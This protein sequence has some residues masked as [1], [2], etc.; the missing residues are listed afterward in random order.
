MRRRPGGKGSLFVGRLVPRK[1]AAVL[2]EAL[3]HLRAE[4]RDPR[5]DIV[6]D[7][8]ERDSLAARVAA[9]GLGGAVRFLGPLDEA[10]VA[11]AMGRAGIVVVPSLEE[12]LPAVIMEAMASRLPV[13]ASGVDAIPELVRDGET[14]LLVPPGD[15]DRLARAIAHLLDRP[16]LA[17]RMGDAGQRLRG[18]RHDAD[19]NA[20]RLLRTI[21][22][23]TGAD[24]DGNDATHS[25]EGKHHAR[26]G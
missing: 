16:E 12:G 25:K 11:R 14:G 6:G 22:G 3:A 9:R 8:P 24:D 4:G 18:R 2:I 20:R 13:V 7:G 23:P 15:P 10:G 1:G 19:R 26:H 5:L 17:R 21:L